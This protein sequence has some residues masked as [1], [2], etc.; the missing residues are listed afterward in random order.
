LAAMHN[1][2]REAR[3]GN[4]EAANAL[5]ATADFIGLDRHLWSANEDAMIFGR[6]ADRALDDRI[7]ALI[8]ARLEARRAKDFAEAD[9]I[10]A[11]LDGMGITLKDAKDPATGEIVTTWEV[12]R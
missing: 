6:A 8:T 11:E 9:R 7:E 5:A 12:K 4:A 1:L 3:R 10:R 2:A